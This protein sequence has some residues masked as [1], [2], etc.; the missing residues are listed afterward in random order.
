MRKPIFFAIG[1]MNPPTIGHLH[2][3]KNCYYLSLKNKAECKIFLT[4]RQDGKNNPLSLDEKF[5]YLALYFP[6]IGNHLTGTLNPYVAIKELSDLDY[7]DVT[8]VCGS[9]RQEM[10][11]DMFERY[12]NHEDSELRLRFD[13][14][15]IISLPRTQI[16]YSG[17]MMRQRVMENDLAGFRKCIPPYLEKNQAYDLFR[18]LQGRLN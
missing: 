11:Q 3:I 17:T 10:Y 4:I 2:L 15:K 13:H 6:E 5:R 12:I 9:D 8:L 16:P 1:R 14:Y 7:K 18:I